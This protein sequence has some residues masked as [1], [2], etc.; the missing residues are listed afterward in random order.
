[1]SIFECEKNYFSGL[2]KRVIETYKYY[3]PVLA[4]FPNL[5]KCLNIVLPDLQGSLDTLEL[6]RGSDISMDFIMEP[7]LIEKGLALWLPTSR[8]NLPGC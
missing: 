5:Y 6:L 8:W 3:H 7:D 4:G 2:A 1:M